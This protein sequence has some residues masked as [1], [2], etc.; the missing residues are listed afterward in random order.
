MARRPLVVAVV[1]ALALVGLAMPAG[2]TNDPFY[3]QQWGL[4]Q[5]HAP[6]TWGRSTGRGVTIAIVDS[7]IDL[8]HPDLARKIVAHESCLNGSCTSGGD[9][10]VGHGSH[11][12]GIAAAVTGNGAGVAGVAPDA[13]LM[14]VKVLT[15][16]GNGTAS[17]SCSDVGLGIRWAVDHGARVINLSLGGS[18]IKLVLIGI[19][20]SCSDLTSAADYAVSKGAV[21]AV[22]A[23]NDGLNGTAYNDPNLIVVGALGPNGQVASSYSNTG[24]DV[25]APGGESNGAQCTAQTCVVSTWI[26]NGYEYD[27]GTSMATPFVSGVAAQLLAEGYSN[28]AAMSRIKTMTSTTPDGYKAL[29][30]A[31]AVGAGGSTTGGGTTSGTSGGGTSGGGTTGHSG[32]SSG[33]ATRPRSPSPSAK[34]SSPASASASASPA[35]SP[36]VLAIRERTAPAGSTD[37]SIPEAI[38]GGLAALVAGSI[39]VWRRRRARFGG[40]R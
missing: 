32:S 38:A 33:T 8:S 18:A 7:G 5:I 37:S 3:S 34:A 22:A 10:D 39:V 31:A 9:D 4:Q 13:R 17:G 11:V 40:T 27:E 35:A 2:A 15:N 14:A 21:V 30:D 19:Q 26:N 28:A 25:Y 24:A 23:G 20:Q 16:Q 6:S 36:S 1:L 12:A 29:N